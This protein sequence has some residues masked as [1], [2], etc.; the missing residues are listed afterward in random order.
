MEH[1][2]KNEILPMRQAL[3]KRLN[4]SELKKWLRDYAMPYKELMAYSVYE[5]VVKDRKSV[6][7]EMKQTFTEM[8]AMV[9]QVRAALAATGDKKSRDILRDVYEEF[10]QK[11]DELK[12][13]LDLIIV[14]IPVAIYA[15][16]ALNDIDK[17]K[18][19]FDDSEEAMIAALRKFHERTEYGSLV[20]RARSQSAR[21]IY[22]QLVAKARSELGDREVKKIIG[23]VWL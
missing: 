21:S 22:E 2:M 8:D 15:K 20:A 19:F 9:E 18:A 6:D 23:R 12:G 16:I 1:P 17:A 4:D 3:L 10:G 11:N 13:N 14:D 5:N 7:Q